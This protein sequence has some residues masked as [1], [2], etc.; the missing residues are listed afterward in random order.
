MLVLLI[1]IIILILLLILYGDLEKRE[2]HNT[3]PHKTLLHS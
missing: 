3:L 1:E 2:I